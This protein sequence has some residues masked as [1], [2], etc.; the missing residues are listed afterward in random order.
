MMIFQPKN[1]PMNSSKEAIDCPTVKCKQAEFIVLK[2][3]KY[4]ISEPCQVPD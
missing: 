1:T 2:K 3:E 4:K